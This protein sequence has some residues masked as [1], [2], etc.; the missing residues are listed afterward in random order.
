MVIEI[1]ERVKI[2]KQRNYLIKLTLGKLIEQSFT[3]DWRGNEDSWEA[4]IIMKARGA[5]LPLRNGWHLLDIHI[6]TSISTSQ[7]EPSTQSEVAT[8]LNFLF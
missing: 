4:N 7:K 3:G 8:L 2:F 6:S 5:L 1:R